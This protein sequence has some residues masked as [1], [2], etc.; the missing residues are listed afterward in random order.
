MLLPLPTLL[1]RLALQIT[2]SNFQESLPI[3]Q[4]ALQDCQFFALDCEMTGLELQDAK[5]EYLDEIEDRYHQ[6]LTS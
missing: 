1:I 3:I 2:R 4:Q 6:V 5:Q